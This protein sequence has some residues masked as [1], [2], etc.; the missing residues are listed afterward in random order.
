MTAYFSTKDVNI[1]YQY[2]Y[3]SNLDKP[4]LV[5]IH[6]FL[7]SSYCY[8]KFHDYLK[9]QFHVLSIDLPPFGKS[10][11]NDFISHSYNQMVD[12]IFQ[13][14]EHLSIPSCYVVGHSMGGQVALR[15]TKRFSERVLYLFLLAPSAFM[16][17]SAFLVRILSL[18]TK[19]PSALKLFLKQ[20]GVR[21][22]LSLCMYDH[23][24][25]SESIAKNYREPY[26]HDAIYPCIINLIKEREGDLSEDGLRQIETPS[27]I[28]WGENDQVLP[29]ELGYEL[30]R[31]MP[32]SSLITIKKTGHLLPEEQP[33]FITDVIK[34]TL[35]A[36]IG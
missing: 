19:A 17:K 10:S 8:R 3:D 34:E 30:I 36:T 13:L 14:L 33:I 11:K 32:N 35:D 25:I 29:L 4:Y 21:E 9:E 27:T 26:L 15:F 31:Y 1:Y 16:E 7:S 22:I 2:T 12:W 6:G 24:L 5:C 20:K 23:E 18:S 28:I